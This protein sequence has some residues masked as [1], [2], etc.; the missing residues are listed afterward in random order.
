MYLL[1]TVTGRGM[2]CNTRFETLRA[3]QQARN[4]VLYGKTIEDEEAAVEALNRA[5]VAVLWRKC[6]RRFSPPPSTYRRYDVS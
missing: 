4:L 3:R 5:K 2:V 1:I 6:Q